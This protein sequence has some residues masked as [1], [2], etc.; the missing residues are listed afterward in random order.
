M[1]RRHFSETF[2]QSSFPIRTAT[3]IS[4]K[5]KA[6]KYQYLRKESRRRHSYFKNLKWYPSH[7]RCQ[8]WTFHLFFLSL[9]T[10]SRHIFTSPDSSTSI[11]TVTILVHMILLYILLFY[12]RGFFCTYSTTYYQFPKPDKSSKF[13]KHLS[14][15]HHSSL[16]IPKSL[17]NWYFLKFMHN[18]TPFHFTTI[19]LVSRKSFSREMRQTSHFS[20][21]KC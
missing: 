7:C 10:S 21:S 1:I 13:F 20:S 14:S 5:K 2:E 8:C 3:N 9:I 19:N 18:L 6:I 12:C 11:Y 15:Y 16:L 17:K 4:L